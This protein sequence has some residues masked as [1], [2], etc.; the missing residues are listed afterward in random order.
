ME[1]TIS[2]TDDWTVDSYQASDVWPAV[3]LTAPDGAK[4]RFEGDSDVLA[5]I[6]R[7]WAAEFEVAANGRNP[8]VI[9]GVN[10]GGPITSEKFVSPTLDAIDAKIDNLEALLTEHRKGEER[11]YPD[12]FQAGDWVQFPPQKAWRK[13][14]RVA[15]TIFA[16]DRVVFFTYGGAGYEKQLRAE[17]RY[18]YMTAATMA[19]VPKQEA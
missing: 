8:D 4:L 10:L 14:D 9:S 7:A 12:D 18:P 17:T 15:E 5:R 13:V 16:T 11:R 3:F 19:A 1:I 6:G 2:L